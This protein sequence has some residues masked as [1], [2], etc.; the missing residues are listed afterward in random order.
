MAIGRVGQTAGVQARAIAIAPTSHA[1]RVTPGRF[2]LGDHSKREA[3][4]AEIGRKFEEAK[5]KERGDNLVRCRSCRK[6]RYQVPIMV[7][8]GGFAFCSECI[9]AAYG[10]VAGKKAGR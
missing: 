3:Q 6:S 9:T 5:S 1:Q 8:M 4:R 10:V 7:E 2:R